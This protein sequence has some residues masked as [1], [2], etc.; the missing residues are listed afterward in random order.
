ML[1]PPTTGFAEKSA[2]EWRPFRRSAGFSAG[3]DGWLF[4]GE[5]NGAEQISGAVRCWK[6]G[7]LGD[8]RAAQFAD[9]GVE[10]V[11]VEPDRVLSVADGVGGRV[12]VFSVEVGV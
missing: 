2:A 10:F 1:N 3:F 6:I 5:K 4:A 7:Q 9:H 12:G 8:D 11:L